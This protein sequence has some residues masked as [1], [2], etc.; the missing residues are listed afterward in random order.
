MKTAILF[1]AYM[2]KYPTA[3]LDELIK[4]FDGLPHEERVKVKQA[5]AEV[6][7]EKG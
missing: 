5:F 2:V 3:K 1:L 7:G 4:L 6:E